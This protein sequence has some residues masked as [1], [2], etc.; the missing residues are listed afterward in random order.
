MRLSEEFKTVTEQL[1]ELYEYRS[2]LEERII[3]LEMKLKEIG[4]LMDF[5]DVLNDSAV[6]G[7][8]ETSENENRD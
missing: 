4:E 8:P 5:A 1:T 6:Y 3:M 2:F 7:Q